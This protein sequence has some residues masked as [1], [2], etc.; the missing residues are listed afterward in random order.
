MKGPDVRMLAVSPPCLTAVNRAIYRFLA[1]EHGFTMHLVVPKRSMVGS[2]WKLCE[3]TEGEP[4]ET[5]QLEMSGPHPRLYRMEGL[6]QLMESWR[7]THILVDNDPA[8]MLVRQV[9]GYTR[10]NGSPRPKVWVLTAENQMPD[11]MR[12]LVAGVR[13]LKPNLIAGPLMTWWLRNS[14]K[15]GVDRVLTISN[16]GSRVMEALGF[17]GRV[18][19]I[20]L[21]FDRQLF[22]PYP[23]EEI[24]AT[25]ARISLNS[26]TIAY[27]GRLT[28]E[29]GLHILLPALASVKDLPWQFL[30]DRFSVYET[31]YT[32]SVK[33]QIETLGLAERVVFFDATHSEMPEYMNAADFVV[34]PSVS[35]PKWKEQYG[36]VIP[37]AMACGKI[38]LGSRTGAIPE[39]I[40]DAG[41]TVP[42]QDP[43]ALGELLR[44]L[45]TQD[46]SSLRPMQEAAV[47]RS[48]TDYS[49]DRQAAIMAELAES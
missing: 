38:V 6:E 46:P 48:H 31:P 35:T 15:S 10:R 14:V 19:K 43:G 44:K 27:F 49:L 29:K 45:L 2:G 39:I 11:T 13:Q 34:L 22:H 16:D 7:P 12:D 24:A 41:Y 32:A 21:G 47:R 28:Y 18:T 3:S 5:T 25:R 37:E 23:P 36:R 9:V 40:G 26:P 17:P 33:S 20:P 30:I 42:E 4:I 1:S 8:A